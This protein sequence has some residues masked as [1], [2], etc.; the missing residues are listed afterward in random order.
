MTAKNFRIKNGLDIGDVTDVITV[1]GGVATFVGTVSSEGSALGN[2]QVGVT[3]D[4]TIDTTSGN[5]TINSTGGTVT[6]D[7]DVS[8]SGSLSF[9][10]TPIALTIGDDASN[11]GSVAI[12]GGTLEFKSSDNITMSVGDNSVAAILNSTIQVN[13]IQALDSTSIRFESDVEMTFGA[14]IGGIFIEGTALTP[15][16]STHI[17]LRDTRLGDVAAPV[18]NQDA[19]NKQYVDESVPQFINDLDNIDAPEDNILDGDILVAGFTDS[20][21]MTGFTLASQTNAGMR[22]PT[23]TTVQRPDVV[24]EGIF[25]LNSETNK[26]EGSID[27]NT[28]QEFLVSELISN[29]DVDSATEQVDSWSATTYRAAKY[30]YTIENSGSGEYQA[31]EIIVT[32]DGTTAYHSEYAKVITGNNDLITFTVGLSAGSVLLYGSAQAPNSVFK[33]KRISMEVA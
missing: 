10:G 23:G 13:E 14:R 20:S 19:A 22:V 29:T 15:L 1:T 32:H 6:I 4:N 7:D 3:D 33:A 2:I 31:G 30:F 9:S 17:S 25:R 24:Y 12:K 11:A 5:L 26:Y 8:I 18:S 16:D 27:G 21:T 28:Y